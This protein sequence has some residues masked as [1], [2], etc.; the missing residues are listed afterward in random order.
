MSGD[1][2][3]DLL[4]ADLGITDEATKE[5]WKKVANNFINYL[6]THGKVIVEN[7]QAGSDTVIGRIE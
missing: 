3:A 1:E 4:I 7:V 2:L 5:A 6:I